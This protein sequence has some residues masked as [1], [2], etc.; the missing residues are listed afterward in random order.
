LAQGAWGARALRLQVWRKLEIT[1][2]MLVEVLSLSSPFFLFFQNISMVFSFKIH[3][4]VIYLFFFVIFFCSNSIKKNIVF[5]Q[6]FL[7]KALGKQ[8]YILFWVFLAMIRSVL[9][10]NYL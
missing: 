9:S 10:C 2:S 1:S 3:F 8:V 5:S 7:D 6:G 4:L